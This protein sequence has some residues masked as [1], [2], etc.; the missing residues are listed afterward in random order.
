MT[1][2]FNKNVN[3]V[4]LVVQTPDQPQDAILIA[5]NIVVVYSDDTPI[6]SCVVEYAGG[7]SATVLVPYADMLQWLE[8]FWA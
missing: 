3:S 6:T 1:F 5:A 4:T 7:N 2:D 8:T